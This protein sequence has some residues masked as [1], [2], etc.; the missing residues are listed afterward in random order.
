M[1]NIGRFKFGGSVRDRHMY[2]CKY[3][4][5]ADFN[6]AV[7][8]QTAKPPNFL[9]IW[10]SQY[11]STQSYTYQIHHS[12]FVSL[13]LMAARPPGG[14]HLYQNTEHTP[15]IGRKLGYFSPDD[16][17]CSKVRRTAFEPSRRCHFTDSYSRA[18]IGQLHSAA[19]VKDKDILSCVCVCVCA[20][21]RACMRMCV[22]MYIIRFSY[23]YVQIL[24]LKN[25]FQ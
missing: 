10:Y 5:L 15:D 14:Q 24:Q 3:E 23:W 22:Y 20:C 7:A 16:L 12:H 17:G 11:S 2:I 6:L 21:V 13:D 25:F 1:Q 18:E 4:I 19:T 8:R 9:A